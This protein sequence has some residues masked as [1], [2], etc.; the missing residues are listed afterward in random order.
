M[1]GVPRDAPQ[2]I[3][4]RLKK[5][6]EMREENMQIGVKLEKKE[7]TA[8]KRNMLLRVVS[9]SPLLHHSPLSPLPPS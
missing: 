8:R 6:T 1:L 5:I 4:A 9:V 7:G 3:D 2:S